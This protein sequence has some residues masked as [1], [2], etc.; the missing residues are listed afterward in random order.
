MEATQ[1]ITC[2]V[3]PPCAGCLN[4]TIKSSN[5][6]LWL[7]QLLSKIS[8]FTLPL[9]MQYTYVN[10]FWK[11]NQIVTLGLL[12]V[13]ALANRYTHIL[14]MIIR[15]RYLVCFSRVIFANIWSYDW[16]NRP[17]GGYQ[18]GSMDLKLTPMLV[19]DRPSRL[20]WGL[21]LMLLAVLEVISTLNS[22]SMVFATFQPTPILTHLPFKNPPTS[23]PTRLSP[24]TLA[25][26]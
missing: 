3:F 18:I 12:D 25:W 5:L 15:H 16:D 7:R 23:H 11:A 4:L 22:V 13:I 14:H 8:Q 6:L 24:T 2:R 10:G 21:Q 9:H 26:N 20:V 1:S 17:H 19:S